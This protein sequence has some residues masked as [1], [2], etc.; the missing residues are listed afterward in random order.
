M[1]GRDRN[2]DA[3]CPLLRPEGIQGQGRPQVPVYCRL[4]NGRVRVPTPAELGSLCF[5]E[6]YRDC[7]GY[8]RWAKSRRA[9]AR[10]RP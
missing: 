3:G 6:R 8:R 7:P 1:K 2:T 4:P 9:A 5:V 10:S